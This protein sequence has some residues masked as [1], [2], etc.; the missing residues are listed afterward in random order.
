MP[1]HR[2]WDIECKV[3]IGG[4]R[5][6]ANR[7]DIED[8][9][10]KYGPVRDVW[11][12]RKPPG[13]AFVEMEDPRDARDASRSL[14]G[15]RICGAR[16]RVEMSDPGKRRGRGG[17]RRSRSRSGGRRGRRSPSYSRS[18]RSPS[19]ERGRG[20]GRSRSP[21]DRKRSPSYDRKRSRSPD[22]KR[23]KESRDRGDSRDRR[24][25]DQD[26]GSRSRSRS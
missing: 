3:F 9:F 11:V 12:A 26:D 4:L 19:Y 10:R 23:E 15:T 5:D 20:G 21:R 2:E 16:C 13:F 8:V 22:F 6:D 18:R 17:D 1:G 14:D 7:Y 24:G 25:G